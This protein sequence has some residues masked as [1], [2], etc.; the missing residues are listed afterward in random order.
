MSFLSV[1]L[2]TFIFPMVAILALGAGEFEAG[3]IVALEKTAFLLIGLP[4]GV[5]VD[6]MRR[7]PV[8]IGADLLRAALLLSIP[9]TWAVGMLTLEQ[10][11]LVALLLGACTVFYDVAYVSFLPSIVERR[12]TVDANGRLE[13]LRSGSV[14]L[15]PVTGGALVGWLGAP[16]ALLASGVGIGASTGW[17]TKINVHERT[18]PMN[19]QGMRRQVMEGPRFIWNEKVIRGTAICT[20]AVNFC[21][22][23]FMIMFEVRMLRD[24]GTAPQTMGYIVLVA[25][26]GGVVGGLVNKHLVNLIG[27]GR[28]IFAAAACMP[29]AIAIVCLAGPGLSG[30]VIAAAGMFLATAA[31]VIFNVNQV[32]YRQTMTPDNMLGRLTASVRMLAWGSMPAGALLAG[33]AGEVYGAHAIMW[34]AAAVALLGALPLLTTPLWKMKE[35]PASNVSETASA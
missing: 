28:T 1:S 29:W 4:A 23:G 19:S 30:I 20:G 10:V 12:L 2:M 35:L 31:I 22:S 6:R 27:F 7:R 34:A 21:F 15:G 9:A 24:L 33:I 18:E 8:L 17:L 14:L 25:G 13:I 16:L 5:W 3:L 32:S 11:Y 26:L